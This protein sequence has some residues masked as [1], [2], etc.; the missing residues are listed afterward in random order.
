MFSEVRVDSGLL[1][2]QVSLLGYP[3]VMFVGEP[4]AIL[5]E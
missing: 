3:V 1:A 4:L 5:L 2:R